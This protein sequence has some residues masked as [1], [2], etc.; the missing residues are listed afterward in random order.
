MNRYKKVIPVGV[1]FFIISMVL[2]SCLED[3]LTD[4]RL[5]DDTRWKPDL[6]LP[7]G[8]KRLNVNEYFEEFT[9][10]EDATFPVYYENSLYELDEYG[11]ESEG[12]VE[13]S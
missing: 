5:D 1:I 9:Q 13:Y 8:E 7:V 12:V 6:S 11:I 3:N 4:I 10:I 2:C